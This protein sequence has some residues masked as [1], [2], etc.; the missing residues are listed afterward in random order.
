MRCRDDVYELAAIEDATGWDVFR[1][2]TLPLMAPVL[3]LLVLRDIILSLQF[4]FVPALVVTEGGPPP[5]ATTYLP[6]VRLPQRLRVP[7]LRVRRGRDDRDDGA[8]PARGWAA[9]APHSSISRALRALKLGTVKGMFRSGSRPIGA[10]AL[11]ALMTLAVLAGCSGVDTTTPS[12]SPSASDGIGSA[13]PSTETTAPQ[14]ADPG[15][16]DTG[17]TVVPTDELAYDP[18]PRTV[19][20]IVERTGGCTILV[21]GQGRFVLVGDIAGY[22]S[23]GSTMRVTGNLTNR[24]PTCAGETGQEL[25]VTS[26]TPA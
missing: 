11:A 18:M 24:P 2:V 21:V 15:T 5:Y 13:A 14:P 22:L 19:T 17:P 6:L 1:R 25:Q 26:A 16:P 10:G 12:L 23:V 8:D 20:G 7:A 9:V 4:S 3:G